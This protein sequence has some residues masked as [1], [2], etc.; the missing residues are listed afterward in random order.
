MVQYKIGDKVQITHSDYFNIVI[1][2]ICM[3]DEKLDDDVYRLHRPPDGRRAG[4]TLSFLTRE[5][6]LIRRPNKDTYGVQ[7]RR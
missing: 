4:K 2:D 3:V 6:R 1:G 5:F 7:N